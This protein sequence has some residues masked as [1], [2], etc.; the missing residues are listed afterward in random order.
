M[1]RCGA[2]R[3]RPCDEPDRAGG[4][5]FRV[6]RPAGGLRRGGRS[7]SAGTGRN[8]MA[9]DF[10]GFPEG[11]SAIV[12]GAASGIGAATA[13]MLCAAGL[14]VIGVDIDADRLHGL[15][16]GPAFPP[17]VFDTGKPDEVARSKEHT[18]ELQS[19]MRLS[20]AVF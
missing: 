12:T 16:P 4:R 6:D 18:S 17:H 2:A 13:Q 20:Y 8:M 1:R 3:R 11:R 9:F 5:T 14:T 7:G 19:L 15:D 10:L